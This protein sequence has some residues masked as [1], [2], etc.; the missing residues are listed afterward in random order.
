MT[1]VK[2]T[3]SSVVKEHPKLKVTEISKKLG[4]MWRA[5]SD[6]EKKQFF[7]NIKKIKDLN[8]SLDK[9]KQNEN[10]EHN[11]NNTEINK[12]SEFDKLKEDFNKLKEDFNKVKEMLSLFSRKQIIIE[13]KGK[14]DSYSNNQKSDIL[15]KELEKEFDN[16][17]EQLLISIFGNNN[18]IRE[19]EK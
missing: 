16:Q 19:I 13:L 1:F 14:N 11:D 15:I 12:T 7:D 3:R 5:M 10:N 2:A 18:F 17:I 4:A 8:V 6:A 9:Q